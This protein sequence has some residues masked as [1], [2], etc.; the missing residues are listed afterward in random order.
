VLDSS[1]DI[2][3]LQFLSRQLIV[4]EHTTSWT[5]PANDKTEHRRQN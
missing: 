3:I 2:Y 4:R 1:T 5:K